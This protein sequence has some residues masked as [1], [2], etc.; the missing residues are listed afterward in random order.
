MNAKLVFYGVVFLLVAAAIGS[1]YLFG[2]QNANHTV[3]TSFELWGLGRWGRTWTVTE[4]I[5]LSGGIGF[6]L[7]ALPFFLLWWR[8]AGEA[9]RLRQQVAIG[10]SDNA[11][12]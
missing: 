12:R 3:L 2:V 4:L 8:K 5:A 6:V 11:F 1:G 10:G 7:G 9:R